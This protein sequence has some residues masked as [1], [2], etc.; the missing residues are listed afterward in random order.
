MK[1]ANAEIIS[2]DPVN[3]LDD[4]QTLLKRQIASARNGRTKDIESLCKQADI[5]VQ[6]IAHL[7][8]LNQPIFETQRGQLQKLYDD[9]QLALTAQKD[10]TKQSLSRIRKGKKAIATYHNNI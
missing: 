10:Q 7:G 3:L 6:K 1:A 4:L 5:L 9:L 8:F 2:S